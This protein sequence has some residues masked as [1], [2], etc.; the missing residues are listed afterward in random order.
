M[1]R[2]YVI[3][4]RSHVVLITL[5]SMVMNNNRKSIRLKNYDYRSNGYYFVTICTH[6]KICYF[7]NIENQKVNLSKLGKIA[8]QF[9]LEI[10]DHCDSV[11]ID[12]F[13]VM[14]NHVHG[15]II[16]NKSMTENVGMFHETSLSVANNED[17][18][19]K[20]MSDLSPKKGSLS[21]IIRSYK[22]A[23]TR[24]SK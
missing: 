12:S 22:S 18:L 20:I 14:P 21:S 16:I 17:D 10:P 3:F 5:K 11:E 13:V 6:E 2:P 23:V 15:I 4:E 24:W 7:G 9:W 19:S 1:E 8:K